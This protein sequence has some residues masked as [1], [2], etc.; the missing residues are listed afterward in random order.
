MLRAVSSSA[1]SPGVPVA[2]HVAEAAVIAGM[3]DACE[4][5]GG[6]GHV[7]DRRERLVPGW[8]GELLFHLCER[9]ANDVV[10]VDVR[11]DRLDGVEP[12]PVNQIEIDGRE[13]GRMRADVI[14]VGA[15][16]AMRD[17]EAGG[18]RFGLVGALPR[19]AEQA[20]LVGARQRGRLADVDLGR[21]QLQHRRG[22]GVHDVARH[23][24]DRADRVAEPL[25]QRGG[26]L[27]QP[28]LLRGGP[29][30]GVR[31]RF[32]LRIEHANRHHDHVAIPGRLERRRHVV[33]RVR[34]AHRQPGCSRAACRAA[35]GDT[36]ASLTTSNAARRFVLASRVRRCGPPS[37]RSSPMPASSVAAATAG[38]VAARRARPA[39]P[40][41][42]RRRWR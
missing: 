2:Q 31:R 30:L 27:E 36:W 13:R 11:P 5:V 10:V 34:V 18:P 40:R 22:D 24:D 17:D 28:A 33:E 20:R 9:R 38:G 32:H 21:L 3:Q 4:L 39:A 42:A 12:H 15:A 16:A 7:A 26:G 41:Q 8:A 29:A 25:G 1:T 19:L 23:H 14:G 35:R 37:A 6:T